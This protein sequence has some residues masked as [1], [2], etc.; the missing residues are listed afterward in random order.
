MYRKVKNDMKDFN[1]KNVR[2]IK[3]G[4]YTHNDEVHNFNFGTDLSVANKRKFVNTIVDILVNEEEKEYNSIIRGLV[5]DFFIIDFFTDI[6]TTVFITSSAFLDDVEQ[7][8]EEVNIVEIVKANM[9]MGL[10]EELNRA[11]DKSIEYRTGIH[12]SP[13]ADSLASL[14]S[15]F[16]KKI[17]EV[18]LDS[19]MGM[20]Q[21][22]AGMTGELTPESIMGAYMNSDIY[23][24]NADEIAESKKQRMK[25][26][27]NLDKAI[28]SINEEESNKTK[29]MKTKQKKEQTTE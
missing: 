18:D 5:F 9:E 6:D 8:L 19:L 14:L 7:Y 25:I 2:N 21:K 12:P 26:A 15:T 28:K 23:K 22:F 13:I 16:E 10:L 27:E 29:T 4:A 24:K 17:N 1:V 20:A 11:I 3:I